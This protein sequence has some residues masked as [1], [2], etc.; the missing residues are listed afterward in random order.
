MRRLAA[1]EQA[2]YLVLVMIAAWS[3]FCMT[4]EKL[5]I[6]VNGSVLVMVVAIK[7]LVYLHKRKSKN[8]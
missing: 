4:N 3:G 1:N 6:A 2:I 8:D 5:K 7:V